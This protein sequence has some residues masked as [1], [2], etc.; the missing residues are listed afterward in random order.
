MDPGPS[1]TLKKPKKTHANEVKIS[2]KV[3]ISLTELDSDTRK[4]TQCAKRTRRHLQLEKFKRPANYD[5]NSDSSNS[6]VKLAKRK[7]IN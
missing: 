1:S 6:E 7:R 3:K 4:A 2:P 5:S